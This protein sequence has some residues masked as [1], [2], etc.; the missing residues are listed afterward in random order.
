MGFKIRYWCIGGN[1]MDETEIERRFTACE[2][3]IDANFER[4]VWLEKRQNNLDEIVDTVKAVA[5]RGERLEE[6]MKEIKTDVKN[7]TSKPG[8]KWEN[9]VTQIITLLVAAI[10]GFIF[11]KIG[12]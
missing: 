7:L 8:K 11:A 10:A 9:L 12:L 1:N 6:D 2:H 3:K 5:L 4:I